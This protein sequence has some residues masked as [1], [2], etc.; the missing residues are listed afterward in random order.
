MRL[1]REKNVRSKLVTLCTGALDIRYM[2]KRGQLNV[3]IF[4]CNAIWISWKDL[5]TSY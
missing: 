2:I 1:S 3:K 5:R 4:K